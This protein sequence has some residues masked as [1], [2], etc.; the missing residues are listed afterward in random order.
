MLAV[1]TPRPPALYLY[2][3]RTRLERAFE[4]GEFRLSP[5]APGGSRNLPFA[6]NKPLAAQLGAYLTL[7]LSQKWDESRLD[8]ASGADCCLM[9]LDVEQFG[10][11]IHRAA[12]KALPNWAGIDAE[13]SY[14]T[15][16]PLGA[17]FSQARELAGQREWL[18]AWRPMQPAK[19]AHP[20]VIAIGALK[21]IAELRGKSS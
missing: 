9:I 13:V 15:P 21:G 12:Q 8:A 1:D 11:R 2:A 6:Q 19:A 4:L 5:I 17:V 3:D 7:S 10:E 16:S 20:I 18:F 14:G